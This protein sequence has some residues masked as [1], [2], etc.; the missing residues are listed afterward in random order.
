MRVPSRPGKRPPTA[1]HAVGLVHDTLC[2]SALKSMAGSLIATIDHVDPFQRMENTPSARSPTAMQSVAVAHDTAFNDV[3]LSGTTGFG[4][5]DQLV[6][7]HRSVA[8]CPTATQAVVL[9]HETPARLAKGG[10]TGLRLGVTVQF[11]AAAA[12]SGTAATPPP[13]T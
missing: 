11:D 1:T 13:S 7:S 6:P 4:P 10:T 12:G 9:A 3:S 8:H 5:T 2:S